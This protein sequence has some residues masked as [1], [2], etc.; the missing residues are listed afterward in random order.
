MQFMCCESF[1]ICLYGTSLWQLFTR[2]T[3]N[4]VGIQLSFESKTGL[5]NKKKGGKS[6]N[7]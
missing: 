6:N 7:L 5:P 1:H 2:T 4:I 3:P